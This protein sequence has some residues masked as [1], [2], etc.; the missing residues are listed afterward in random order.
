MCFVMALG[1]MAIEERA[2]EHEELW[3]HPVVPR[4][5]PLAFFDCLKCCCVS[6]ELG[7]SSNAGFGE[8]RIFD[9]FVDGAMSSSL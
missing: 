8:G 5:A 3:G 2:L 9:R 7:K 4:L 1:G 6:E